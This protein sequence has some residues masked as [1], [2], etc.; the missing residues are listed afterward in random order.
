VE[1]APPKG[2]DAAPVPGLPLMVS[3]DGF[4]VLAGALSVAE[5]KSDILPAPTEIELDDEAIEPNFAPVL[6]PD[7][8]AAV[9][10]LGVTPGPGGTP[11]KTK[12]EEVPLGAITVQPF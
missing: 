1:E 7:E 6:A 5:E 8:A 12:E 10:E 4:C 2:E 3:G 9:P 11:V